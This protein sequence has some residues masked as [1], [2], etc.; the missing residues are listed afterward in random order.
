MALSPNA[1]LFKNSLSDTGSWLV[2]LRITLLSGTI[3]RV[4]NNNED[5]VWPTVD[6]NTYSA[7]RK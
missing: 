6:G 3:I 1:Y 7:F 5:V 4:V 2:L